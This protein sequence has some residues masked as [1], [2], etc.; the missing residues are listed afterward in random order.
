MPRT[1]PPAG[2]NQRGAA[3]P[4]RRRAR[5][6][7]PAIPARQGTVQGGPAPLGRGGRGLARTRSPAQP[8]C[9]PRRRPWTSH[10]DALSL[11]D[12]RHLGFALV[13]SPTLRSAIDLALRYLE[14]TYTFCDI[15]PEESADEFRLVFDDAGIPED[16]RLF[17]LERDAA[18][19]FTLQRE[20]FSASISLRRLM[21]R[22]RAPPYAAARYEPV[23]GNRRRFPGQLADLCLD[24]DRGRPYRLGD[25]S[26]RRRDDVP[27]ARLRRRQSGTYPAELAGH[28]ARQR[29]LLSSAA[30]V[31]AW[32]ASLP[33]AVAGGGVPRRWSCSLAV[34]SDGAVAAISASR[35]E[36]A[37]T[38]WTI[39]AGPA[40]FDLVQHA[41]DGDSESAELGGAELAAGR[42][43]WLFGQAGCGVGDDGGAGSIFGAWRR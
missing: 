36:L 31:A 43:P 27:P 8:G 15:F 30:S 40:S 33:W 23:F 2:S 11:H 14:L 13:S 22:H 34:P 32:P 28:P 6:P 17:L 20:V 5:H 25:E 7:P 3:R 12:L 37:L 9:R 35:R 16:A 26:R 38:L 1:P 24:A 18:A 39:T 4:D 19:A 21:I 42:W 41:V 29:R 10:R